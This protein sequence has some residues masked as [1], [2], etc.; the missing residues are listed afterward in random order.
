[1]TPSRRLIALIAISTFSM[2]SSEAFA[3]QSLHERNPEQGHVLVSLEP[4]QLEDDEVVEENE[5]RLEED[6]WRVYLDLYGFLPLSTTGDITINGNTAPIDSSLADVLA[7]V[8]GLFTGRASVE[9]GR[10]GFMA[11]IIYGTSSEDQSGTNSF[12][13]EKLNPPIDGLKLN[14][15]ST[16]NFNQSVVDLALCYR[17]GAI[18]QPVMKTGD[19]TFIG[20]VGARIIDAGMDM[21]MSLAA[22]VK[23]NGRTLTKKEIPELEKSASGSIDRTWAQPLLG[24]QVTYAMSPEWQAFMRLDAGGFGLSGK[25]DLSGTAQAGLAYT[26]GNSAQLTLSWKYFGLEYAGYNTDNSYSN[27]Q[28]GVNLGLRWFFP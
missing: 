7:T 15:Q 18:E 6:D 13:G 28:N 11:G 2:L 9:Y 26:V 21:D 17:L 5:D 25:K 27:Y 4:D 16:T 1:M 12:D 14:S 20:F 24:M 22:D 10:L 19:S 3:E 8:T 23:V